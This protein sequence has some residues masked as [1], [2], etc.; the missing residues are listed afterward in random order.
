MGRT[1][2][3]GDIHGAYRALRQCL[4]RAAFDYAKDTL[5]SLGDVSDGWPQT[6]ECIDE[7]LKIRKLVYILGNHDTWAREWMHHGLA[8]ELW[9]EQGGLATL[10][11][12]AKGIPPRHKKLLDKALPYYTVKKKLFVHAGIDPTKKLKQQD[13]K[14]FLWDRSLARTALDTHEKDSAAKLT[15]YDEVY[16]GHTPISGSQPFKACEVWLMDTGAG[17]TGCLSMM[18]INTKEVFTSD[19]VPT[20]YPGIKGRERRVRVPVS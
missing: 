3:V 18:E 14:T 8:D 20:L 6:R 4:D 7:L 11:S 16:I 9:L 2:V 19:P 5:I 17:W 13:L 1:F 15:E 10:H 12:Y